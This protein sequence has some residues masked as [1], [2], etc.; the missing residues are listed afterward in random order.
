MIVTVSLQISYD[1]KLVMTIPYLARWKIY[2]SKH[3]NFWKRCGRSQRRIHNVVAMLTPQ[4]QNYNI[5]PTLPQRWVVSLTHVLLQILSWQC[6]FNVEIVT[7]NSQRFHNVAAATS[8]S[9]HCTNVASTLD[10]KFISQHSI[11]VVMATLVR[12]WNRSVKLTT[13]SWRRY[14]V[15]AHILRQLCEERKMWTNNGQM[16]TFPQLFFKVVKKIYNNMI[17][18]WYTASILWLQTQ[19]IISLSQSKSF[20]KLL[21]KVLETSS[22]ISWSLVDW[23]FA[24][25]A[26]PL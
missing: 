9:Q 26:C 10:S 21:L 20:Q 23:N 12:R 1:Y 15:V 22:M 18:S 17:F 7:S 11:N 25:R 2:S 19:S 13:S 8:N 4:I 14:Y 24:R 5:A 6:C 16:V 3:A